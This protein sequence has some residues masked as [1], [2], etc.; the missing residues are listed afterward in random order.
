MNDSTNICLSCGF[1]CDGTVIGFVQIGREEAPALR[2]LMMDTENANGEGFF[3]QP[4][5]S[6]CDGCSIYSRR[7]RQCAS[8]ECALLESFEQGELDFNSAIGIVDEVKQR[9]A[10]IEGRLALLQLELQSQSFYFK[11][12]ELN[13]LIMKSKPGLLWTHNH[14]DLVSDLKQLDTLLSK[15]FGVSLLE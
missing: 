6:Y 10:D 12:A 11:M 2:E 8:F 4:C 14:L 13:K 3:L 5:K 9:K 1:C 7:P 15:E